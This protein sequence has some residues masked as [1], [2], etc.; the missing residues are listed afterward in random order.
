MNIP[1]FCAVKLDKVTFVRNV[2]LIQSRSKTVALA[3]IPR[4][5]YK[6][7]IQKDFFVESFQVNTRNIVHLKRR[8]GCHQYHGASYLSNLQGNG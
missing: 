2:F 5:V 3:P 6:G 8:G 4:K 7:H 1:E